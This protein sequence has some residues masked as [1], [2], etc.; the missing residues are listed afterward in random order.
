MFEVSDTG[1]IRNARRGNIL[2]QHKNVKGYMG[3]STKI[4]GRMGKN[5][6]FKIHRKVAEC[7]IDNPENKPQVNH[8]DGD[9]TN[10]H[11]S[12][13]EWV[14]ASENIR[15]ALDTGLMLPPDMTEYRKLD[16]EQ[17]QH[18]LD[19]YKPH[20]REYGSRALGRKFGVDKGTIV[21]V[22]TLGYASPQVNRKE[23]HN[24]LQD[25]HAGWHRRH[26][27]EERLAPLHQR[28][29]QCWAD[30]EGS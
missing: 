9:K 27:G 16:E 2:K 8:I 29:L 15:H 5:V 4:G 20:S 22:Y 17:V 6:F 13:L 1:E 23:K 26:Y 3:L 30:T 12:N 24:G 10:N 7:Y 28:R 18:V 14:T 25:I 11:V 19:H 21:K